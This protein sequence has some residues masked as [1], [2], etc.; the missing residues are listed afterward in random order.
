MAGNHNNHLPVASVVVLLFILLK[1]IFT[2]SPG[3]AHPQI[4]I[5]T[6][7]CNTILSLINRGNFTSANDTMEY[8]NKPTIAHTFVRIY[9]YHLIPLVL[10][11]GRPFYHPVNL[12]L[13]YG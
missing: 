12:R 5:L 1:S 7:R 4:F 2:F 3:D 13:R 9:L 6:S 10:R 8:N 11:K